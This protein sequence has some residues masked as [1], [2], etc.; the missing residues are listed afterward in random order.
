MVHAMCIY[1]LEIISGCIML[2]YMGMDLV[3]HFADAS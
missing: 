1:L 3:N 2:M